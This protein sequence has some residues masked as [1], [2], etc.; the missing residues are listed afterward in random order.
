[1]LHR[2][3]LATSK[4]LALVGRVEPRDFVDT[5]TCNETVQ[6][7]GC[8]AWAACAKDPGF[9]PPA[10]LEEAARANRYS[11]TELQGLAFEDQPPDPGELSRRWHAML[12]AAREMVGTLPPGDVGR[13]LLARGGGLFR[14]DTIALRAALADG[15]VIFHQGSIR[16]AMPRLV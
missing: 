7:F 16:G 3:D 9:G 10:I 6:P 15:G 14:G 1:M 12:R 13:A 2:F 8:L 4:V 11:S 5:L